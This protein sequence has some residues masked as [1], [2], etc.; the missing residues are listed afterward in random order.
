MGEL[1]DQREDSAGQARQTGGPQSAA[2]SPAA[3]NLLGL[4]AS[5]GNAAVAQAMDSEING[6]L[7]TIYSTLHVGGMSDDR[8]EN[9]L[10]LLLANFPSAEKLKAGYQSQYKLDL[11]RDLA[12]LPAEKAVRARDYLDT[13]TLRTMTK[14]LISLEGAGTD[15]PT[16]WRVLGDAHAEG[17]PEKK[18]T[19]VAGGGRLDDLSGY[20]RFAGE[21]LD[22]ALD[23]DLDGHELIRA[24][25]ILKFGKPRDIDELVIAMEQIGTDEAK[26]FG[27]LGT[28]GKRATIEQEYRD[29]ELRKYTATPNGHG[30]LLEDLGAEMDGEDY[31]H[32]LAL[33]GYD[34]KLKKLAADQGLVALV[35]AATHGL[36]TNN[37]LIWDSVGKASPA[38][39]AALLKEVDAPGDPLGLKGLT[40]D[41][42][43]TDHARL[44]A[45]LLAPD[46]AVAT[47]APGG[48]TPAPGTTAVPA[49]P[50]P[51]EPGFSSSG[52]TDPAILSDPLVLRLR[53]LGGVDTLT[54]FD[55]LKMAKPTVWKAFRDAW[56]DPKSP[57]H[58]YVSANTVVGEKRDLAIVLGTDLRARLDYCIGMVSDD[59]DYLFLLLEEFATDSDRHVLSK[60]QGFRDKVLGALSSSEQ[61][62]A[63]AALRPRDQSAQEQAD[64]LKKAVD[65]ESSSFF[66][67]FT[68]TGDALR[69]EKRELAQKAAGPSGSELDKQI[70][71]TSNALTSYTAARDEFANTASMVVNIAV[72][73]IAAVLTGGAAGPIV[74]AQLAR[75]AAAMALTR[76][77]SEKV[78]R[79]DRFDVLGADGAVAF[80][81]GATDG[82]MNVLGGVAARGISTAA[83]DAMGPTVGALARTAHG[84]A[85]VGVLRT[86]LEGGLS[87]GASGMVETVAKDETWRQGIQ[88]GV[89]TSIKAAGAGAGQGALVAVGIHTVSSAISAMRLP[90]TDPAR[91]ALRQAVLDGNP[92]AA[93]GFVA[94][95]ERWETGIRDLDAGTGIG[96][97]LEPGVRQQLIRRVQ[98]HRR[99]LVQQLGEHFDAKPLGGASTEAISD[100]DLSVS[101]ENAGTNLLAAE[102][103]LDGLYP[104][105]RS[106]YRMGLMVDATRI[107]TY[108]Q[109][110][111]GLPPQ[112]RAAL[113][114]RVTMEVETLNAARRLR[115]ASGPERG[116]LLK[117][118]PAGIAPE[119]V[120]ILAGLG[121]EARQAVRDHALVEGDKLL[122]QLKAATDPAEKARLAE[123]VTY[124]QMLANAMSDDAYLSP[125]GVKGFALNQPLSGPHQHYQAALDQLDMAG[126]AIREAGGVL[127]AMRSYELFKYINRFSVIVESAGLT[128][129]SLNFFKNW[130]D[131]VYR[132]DRAAT[133]AEARPGGLGSEAKGAHKSGARYDNPG[134]ALDAPTAEFL[135]GRYEEF[136]A[137]VARHTA[138]LRARTQPEGAEAGSSGLSR[139]PDPT[140]QD[141]TPSGDTGDGRLTPPPV[142]LGGLEAL[143]QPIGR[144]VVD[145]EAGQ[146]LIRRLA[147]NDA[148]ALTDIGVSLPPKF[149]PEGREWGLA[150]LADGTYAIIQGSPGVIHWPRGSTPLGHTHP[151]HAGRMIS[152]GG[153]PITAMAD[154]TVTSDTAVYLQ[155]VKV[156]PS[157]GDIGLASA[158]GWKSHE[159]H[160]PYVHLGDGRIGNP[161]AAPAAPRLSF[162]VLDAEI[163]GHIDIFDVTRC[164]LQAVADGKVIWEGTVWASNAGVGTIE[165]KPPTTLNPGRY[166]DRYRR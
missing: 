94:G 109:A 58:L 22:V 153:T 144:P 61:N 29:Y 55:T 129:P 116:L 23:D 21:T 139:L 133:G 120:E 105:W 72:G 9:V 101:G 70:A 33:L 160:T 37:A 81:A 59:E 75:A 48:T 56:N 156:F 138:E 90:A 52:V 3:A 57:F 91:Q 28:A 140:A 30:V 122:A 131:L 68:D 77:L 117:D 99:Q 14:L 141:T 162:R 43:D 128:D 63:E 127:E 113:E 98:E 147:S 53:G 54:V 66:D 145:E 102:A 137:F 74:A 134:E 51:D 84:T 154:S 73:V 6:T 159:V 95:M 110:L 158:K 8:V 164:Q 125:G 92:E 47:P 82:V 103:F 106:K 42:S 78:I 27:A 11:Y 88:N 41:L 34:E 40:G 83:L 38:E 60:D 62:R 44:R 157:V 124:Q 97:G 46:P 130:S 155:K 161:T 24:H 132:V 31:R 5:A 108:T 151:W 136:Q 71:K 1:R 119:R 85:A 166:S 115:N 19:E 13:G 96:A 87:G 135:L 7:E 50:G 112:A 104:G 86:S 12:T 26:L 111:E 15:L 126:H 143:H 76:V 18:W 2:L 80:A 121:D 35:K 142:P 67:L 89:E 32:A 150:R 49:P 4:Q 114:S 65:R 69:D 39:K 93:K 123:Q 149:S 20:S 146:A 163:V 16:L 100:V 10:R 45:M 118:L 165:T 152:E 148:S 25:A 107:G 79:G 17:D 36:G 64:W